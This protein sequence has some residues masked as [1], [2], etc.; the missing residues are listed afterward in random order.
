MITE[1]ELMLTWRHQRQMTNLET[2]AQGIIDRKDRAVTVAHDEIRRLQQALRLET[3]RR[4]AAEIEVADLRAR[5]AKLAAL[6][7]SLG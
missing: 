6:A 4:Q 7:R 5:N 3:A 1:G 2:A